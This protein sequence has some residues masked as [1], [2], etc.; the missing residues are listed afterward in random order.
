MLTSDRKQIRSGKKVG[1]RTDYKGT[2]ANFLGM[3]E[4]LC[5]MIVT[6]FK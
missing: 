5:I 2:G 3:M 1:A 4:L 6:V